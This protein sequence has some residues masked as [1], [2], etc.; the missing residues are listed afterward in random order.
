MFVDGLNEGIGKH[1]IGHLNANG[2]KLPLKERVAIICKLGAGC[3][4]VVYK[5]LDISPLRLVALKTVP[6]HDR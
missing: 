6:V 3:S 4:G 2:S 5:A 1:G